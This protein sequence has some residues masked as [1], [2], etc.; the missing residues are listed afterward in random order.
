MVDDNLKNGCFK[1]D[2]CSHLN[3]VLIVASLSNYEHVPFILETV[4][5]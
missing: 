1:K 5:V 4:E 3:G 2:N